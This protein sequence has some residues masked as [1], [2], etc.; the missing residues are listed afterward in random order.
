VLMVIASLLPLIVGASIGCPAWLIVALILLRGKRGVAKATAFAAG[1]IA[2]RT[3]QFALFGRLFGT[4]ASANGQDVF[5]LI[6]STLLLVA[7]LVLVITAVRTWWCKEEDSDAPPPRW[8]TVLGA[9]ST[10]V[11]FGMAVVLMFV[12]IKQWVFTLSAIAVIDDAYLSKLETILAYLFFIVMAQLLML[13]PIISSAV[14]P[15]YSARMR[16]IVLR[17]LERNSRVITIVVSLAFGAWFLS[18]GV[19]GLVAHGGAAKMS[20]N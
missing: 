2:V 15:L 7:G 8:M 10:P 1:V 6:P 4:I 17:W 11:A 16:E 13:A 14:A 18:K 12:A 20:A 9:M 3:L 19:T 5:D